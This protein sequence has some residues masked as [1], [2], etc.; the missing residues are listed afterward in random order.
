[1][2]LSTIKCEFLYA[3]CFQTFNCIYRLFFIFE[4]Y[5]GIVFICNFLGQ[6]LV[7]SVSLLSCF[8]LCFVAR[9]ILSGF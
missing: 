2:E 3:E 9:V 8:M 4:V 1:M 6:I 7:A 5:Y